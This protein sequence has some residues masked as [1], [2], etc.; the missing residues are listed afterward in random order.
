MIDNKRQIVDMLSILFETFIL[1]DILQS[2]ETSSNA[3]YLLIE[4]LFLHLA[5]SVACCS[6]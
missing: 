3:G 1:V 4:R 2:E 6:R 5:P